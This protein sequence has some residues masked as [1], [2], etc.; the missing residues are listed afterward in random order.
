[1]LSLLIL[2]RP[3]L[4]LGLQDLL[5]NKKLMQVQMI[6]LLFQQSGLSKPL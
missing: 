3:K 1:M 6:P 4:L 5:M 2:P